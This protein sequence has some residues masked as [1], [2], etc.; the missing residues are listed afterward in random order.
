MYVRTC[1]QGKIFYGWLET[2]RY[3]SCEK[4]V[5]GPEMKMKRVLH[6]DVFNLLCIYCARG[7]AARAT[8]GRHLK[9]NKLAV[10][11]KKAR[12]VGAKK[13]KGFVQFLW[14]ANDAKVY[15]LSNEM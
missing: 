12:K 8:P 7:W 14:E 9:E 10:R 11:R 4:I 1:V 15:L 3:L 13:C 2:D 5:L 6:T